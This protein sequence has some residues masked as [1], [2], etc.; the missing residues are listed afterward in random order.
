MALDALMD[1]FA[2]G[3]NCTLMNRRRFSL[4]VLLQNVASH[5]FVDCGSM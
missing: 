5:D 3:V 4:P 1:F 2:C